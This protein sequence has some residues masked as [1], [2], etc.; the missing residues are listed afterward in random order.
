MKDHEIG[1][2]RRQTSLLPTLVMSKS[3]LGMAFLTFKMYV[4]GKG[5]SAQMLPKKNLG[6]GLRWS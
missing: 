3:L 2:K 1:H 4:F 5:Y 6:L